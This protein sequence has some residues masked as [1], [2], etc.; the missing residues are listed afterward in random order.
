MLPY[1]DDMFT[2]FGFNDGDD[3]PD[4]IERLR[5]LYIDGINRY[6]ERLGSQFQAVPYDRPGMH[7]WCLI[8]F[9]R[10]NKRMDKAVSFSDLKD[11][12][13]KP[14]IS[15]VGHLSCFNPYEHQ[16]YFGTKIV[17]PTRKAFAEAI[18]QDLKTRKDEFDA[19]L[20]EESEDE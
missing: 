19:E 18:E 16:L 20:A 9:K 7:N 14:M 5:K 11:Q 15:A 2:K 12:L 8:L 3:V 13:D 10:R 4:G 1:L 6:A 17:C